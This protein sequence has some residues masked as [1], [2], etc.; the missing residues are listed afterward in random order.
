M[1]FIF[2]AWC[3][4]HSLYSPADLA[5]GI[6]TENGLHFPD[7]PVGKNHRRH[8]NSSRLVNGNLESI[9][10]EK[11]NEVTHTDNHFREK[12]KV[13]NNQDANNG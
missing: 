1:Y 11:E 13:H 7:R 6:V 10:M 9:G 12:A 4:R 5:N 8:K 3:S 2:L